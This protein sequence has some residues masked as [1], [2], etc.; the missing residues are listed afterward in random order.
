MS[1]THPTHPIARGSL[2]AALTVATVLVLVLVPDAVQAYAPNMI[3]PLRLPGEPAF[4]AGHRGDRAEAP[5][6]TL[7]AFEAAFESGLM[8]VETD[9]QLTA[10]GYPVL[11]HDPTVDRTTNGSGPIAD[12]TLAEVQELDAGAW[13]GDEFTGTRVPQL[14]EFLDL[15][16]ATPRTKALIELKEYWTTDQI[17]GVLGDIYLRGVQNRIVFAGF[18]LGTIANLAEMA[19]AIPRVIIRRDLPADPVGLAEFYGAIAIMTSPWSLETYPDAVADMHAAGYGVLLY[20][21]NSE[22]RW[23]EATAYGVDGIVTDEPS[24]LDDWIAATAPG[25]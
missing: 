21:L 6:N 18:H 8:I 10:D 9:V 7:P 15:L 4:V 13:F 11:L 12:L 20:T 14:G 17:R 2:A 16:A 3:G 25:T 19:A 23:G 5:E 1:T 22:K 24:A